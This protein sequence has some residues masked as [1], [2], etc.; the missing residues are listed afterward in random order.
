M[1]ILQIQKRKPVLFS[2]SSIVSIGLRTRESSIFVHFLPHGFMH[3]L[4]ITKCTLEIVMGDTIGL[5]KNV[6]LHN[7]FNDCFHVVRGKQGEETL[8]LPELSEITFRPMT[9]VIGLI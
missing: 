2:F 8:S 6:M 1:E 4:S 5:S 7:V 9:L 3:T